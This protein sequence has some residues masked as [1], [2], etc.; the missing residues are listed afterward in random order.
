MFN[1]CLV[2]HSDIIHSYFDLVEYDA[3][4]VGLM[5]SWSSSAD[6][7]AIEIEGQATVRS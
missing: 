6:L 1:V 4:V 5:A 7:T 2:S 3:R